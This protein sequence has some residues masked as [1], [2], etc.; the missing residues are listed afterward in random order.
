MAA[1][2]IP[3]ALLV[4]D[5]PL[6]QKAARARLERQG[7]TVFSAQG[8]TEALSQARQT[9][10]DVIY[11]HLVSAGGN[12][13]LIQALRAD[14]ACRHIPVGV[15]REDAATPSSNLKSVPRSGW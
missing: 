15:I 8:T 9:R 6:S 7:Y 1:S 13:P 5:D 14:D 4:D 2:R 12:L 10:P 3:T 11:V